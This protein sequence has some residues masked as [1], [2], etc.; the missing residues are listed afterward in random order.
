MPAAF[1]TISHSIDDSSDLQTLLKPHA[2]AGVEPWASMSKAAP[3]EMVR[4]YRPEDISIV[5]L[6]GETQAA[7]KLV[8]GTL[9][10]ATA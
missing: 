8:S 10:R 2:V 9:S 7:W 4:K 5:V 6:G 1:T 3:D